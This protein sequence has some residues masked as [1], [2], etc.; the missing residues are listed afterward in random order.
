MALSQPS[1]WTEILLFQAV[2]NGLMAG[3]LIAIPAIGF[4]LIF[5]IMRFINFAIASYMTVGAFCG[6]VANVLLG[7][8]IT[9]S[10]LFAFLGAGLVGLVTDELALR[11]LRKSGPIIV[12]IGSLALNIALENV[13]RFFFGNGLQAYNLPV[14]PDMRVADL[15]F[16]GQQAQSFGVAIALM[17]VL[18]LVLKFTLVGRAMRAVADNHALAYLKGINPEKIGRIAVF[19]GVGLVGLG[20]M[21]IGLDSAIDPLTGYRVLLSV[22]AAVVLGGLGSVPGAVIGALAI[23]VTEEIALLVIPPTY[24]PGIGFVVILVVLLFRPRGLFGQ[25]GN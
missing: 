17:V 25:K 12:A 6:F 21:L 22:Y 15:R 8:P 24:R 3:G 9:V 20:G 13:I 18:Y 7:L 4:T 14:L 1:V 16:S 19:A 23:G 10:L 5:A 11:P 2:L